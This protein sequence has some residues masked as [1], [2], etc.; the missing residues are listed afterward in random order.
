MARN[1]FNTIQVRKP[2]SS[3]FD[4]SHDLKLG[5]KMGELVPVALLECIPGDKWNIR[6]EVMLRMAP[7]VAPVMHN[8][9]VTTHYFFVPNRLVWPNWEKFITDN[10][11][12][13]NVPAPPV[14]DNLNIVSG[15]LGEL[16]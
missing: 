14:L 12:K 7:M 3:N 10:N 9:T 15:S 5:L 4:M 1:I 2:K 11:G 16:S 13:G 8:V 6:T